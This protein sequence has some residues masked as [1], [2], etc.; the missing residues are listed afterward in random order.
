MSMEYKYE[1][2]CGFKNRTIA[3]DIYVNH[4]IYLMVGH[5]HSNFC[6]YF[7]FWHWFSFHLLKWNLIHSENLLVKKF[8]F[9]PNKVLLK[10]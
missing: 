9:N 3:S 2:F 6:D 1:M 7:F 5:C 4:K 10:R 8:E